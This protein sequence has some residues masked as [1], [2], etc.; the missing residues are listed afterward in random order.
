METEEAIEIF[1]DHL[2]MKDGSEFI[3]KDWEDAAIHILTLATEA[4]QLKKDNEAMKLVIGGT[5]ALLKANADD[6]EQLR[7]DNYKLADA[8]VFLQST[9]KFKHPAMETA[10]R[11]IENGNINRVS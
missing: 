5:K 7:N 2:K 1:K 8:L 11:I 9:L 3:W 6:I 4:E 10:K